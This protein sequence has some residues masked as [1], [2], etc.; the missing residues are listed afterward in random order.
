MRHAGFLSNLI[1]LNHF[2]H[3]PAALGNGND[4]LVVNRPAH[5]HLLV[6]CRVLRENRDRPQEANTGEEKTTHQMLHNKQNRE[7]NA[8]GRSK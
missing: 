4:C 2:A 7:V 5:R 8:L 1:L 3:E 6:P